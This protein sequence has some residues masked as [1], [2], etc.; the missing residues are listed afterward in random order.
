MVMPLSPAPAYSPLSGTPVTP[1]AST[2]F[3]LD[4]RVVESGPIVEDLYQLTN[5]N[6]G[7]T[8]ETACTSCPK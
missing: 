5:D 6:C 3:D 2:G 8:C 4:I 7:T 1:V